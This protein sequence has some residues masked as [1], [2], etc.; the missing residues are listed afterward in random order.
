[1][2]SDGSDDD[3]LLPLATTH[4]R[5]HSVLQCGAVC[6]SA[7]QSDALWCSVLQCVSVRWWCAAASCYNSPS[8]TQ[9]VAVWCSVVRCI[10]V[11]FSQMMMCYCLVLEPQVHSVVQC[12]A[13]WCSVVQCGAVCCSALQSDDDGQLLVPELNLTFTMQRCDMAYV[14]HDSLPCVAI[15]GAKAHVDNAKIRCRHRFFVCRKWPLWH[16]HS[17]ISL[18]CW[19]AR[20]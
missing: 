15:S 14:R 9:C 8:G 5:V 4:P 19:S 20:G 2:A 1:M 16:Q 11:R 17:C 7:F 13:V 3:T 10:P 18:C 12:G 6:C